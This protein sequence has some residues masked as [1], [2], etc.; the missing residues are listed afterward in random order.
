MALG[1]NFARLA[2]GSVLLLRQR[3]ELASLELE[4]QALRLALLLARAIVTALLLALALFGAGATVI[5]YF[6]DAARVAAAFGVTAFF[7]L[8]A[9]LAGWKLA[10]ALRDKPAF[11]AATLAELDK[12][13]QRIGEAP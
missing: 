5:I 7:A 6:W 8:A 11:L 3:L 10:A 2:A 1:R 4:E 9:L 13:A 12:D